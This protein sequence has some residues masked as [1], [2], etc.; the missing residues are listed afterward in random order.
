MEFERLVVGTVLARFGILEV[1]VPN[2]LVDGSSLDRKMRPLVPRL[3]EQE[4][5]FEFELEPVLVG[6]GSGFLDSLEQ[7][8]ELAEHVAAVGC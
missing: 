2:R 1:A 8:I 5:R 6:T 7:R 4:W 3:V